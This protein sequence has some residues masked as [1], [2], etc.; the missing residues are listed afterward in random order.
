MKENFDLDFTK[1]GSLD[2]VEVNEMSIDAKIKELEGQIAAADRAIGLAEK[3]NDAEYRAKAELKKK[4]FQ[5]TLAMLSED[6]EII[7]PVANKPQFEVAD[8]DGDVF[9]ERANLM[10]RTDA[11]RNDNPGKNLNSI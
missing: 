4:G 9:G 2:G 11:W 6:K 5:E 7:P 3:L 10:N 1:P 8:M